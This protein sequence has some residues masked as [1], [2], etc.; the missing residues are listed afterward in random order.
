[1]RLGGSAAVGLGDFPVMVLGVLGVL[2]IF[3]VFSGCLRY[4]G[5]W[6]LNCDF[7]FRVFSFC[8]L[9]L[10][11][12]GGLGFWVFVFWVF[13]VWFDCVTPVFGCLGCISYGCRFCSGLDEMFGGEFGLF[14]LKLGLFVWVWICIMVLVGFLLFGDCV[15]AYMG[16]RF[17]LRMTWL[18]VFGLWVCF[19][20]M[21]WV[22]VLGCIDVF[23]VLIDVGG[24]YVVSRCLFDYYWVYWYDD[25]RFATLL[26]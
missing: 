25:L 10:W 5:F 26:L 19:F 7:G 11:C 12:F 4:L 3:W 20:T 15:I 21:V 9:C 18:F 24:W 13:W 6:I 8:L 14:A 2:T 23:G 22:L 1:M 16:Y 17:G